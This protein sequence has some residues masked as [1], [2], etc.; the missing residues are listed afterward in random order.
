MFLIVLRVKREKI[1]INPNEDKLNSVSA[2]FSFKSSFFTSEGLN[3]NNSR[4]SN[5]CFSGKRVI[6]QDGTCERHWLICERDFLAEI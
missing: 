4:T 1:I 3:L 2:R 5:V 6:R